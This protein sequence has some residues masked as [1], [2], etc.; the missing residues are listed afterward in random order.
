MKIAT[1]EV[2][3][4]GRCPC[5]DVGEIPQGTV[6]FKPRK[7]EQQVLLIRPLWAQMRFPTASL[8]GLELWGAL[9]ARGAPLRH[10]T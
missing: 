8:F 1:G 5:K 7:E 10:H 6:I 9:V 3:A 4:A 2:P